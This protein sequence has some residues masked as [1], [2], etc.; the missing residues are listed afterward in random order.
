MEKGSDVNAKDDEGRTPIFEACF[1]AKDNAVDVVRTLVEHGASVSVHEERSGFTPLH[2]AAQTGNL[3]VVKFLVEEAG[4][5]ATA[6]NYALDTA[7]VVAKELNYEA[8]RQYLE[9]REEQ[10][11]RNKEAEVF[12]T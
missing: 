6:V 11:K 9:R 2:V 5:D 4:A 10:Q 12:R 8:V 1:S 7:A 3:A